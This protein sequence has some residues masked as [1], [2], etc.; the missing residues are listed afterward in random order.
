MP[1]EEEKLTNDLE[2]ENTED[3]DLSYEFQQ[4]ENV[5]LVPA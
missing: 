2:E 4:I 1:N 3:M 5:E